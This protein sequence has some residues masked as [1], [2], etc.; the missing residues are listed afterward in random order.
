MKQHDAVIQAMK[1]NGGYATLGHL[2]RTAPKIPGSEWKT[3]TPFASIRRI[4]QE[5]PAFFRIKPGLWA[6]EAER[7]RI[8]REFALTE[9]A[10]REKAEEFNHSYYQ[11]L[12][13]ELGNLKNFETFV[14][15]QDKNKLFLSR[16]LSEVA[17]LPQYHE[18]TYNHLLRRGRTVDVTWFNERRLPNAFFEV[19][20]STDIQNSLLKFVEFQDFKVRF[21]I[22]ADGSRREEFADKLSRTVFK[23]IRTEVNFLDYD[24]LSVLHSRESERVAAGKPFGL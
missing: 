17:T 4:V 10:P 7:K 8:A 24:S 12:I 19:E 14:P 3:K 18:F 22:V 15:H 20:H 2:Y 6:L 16:K 9:G 21:F 11:G 23:P 13:V 5:H 1:D